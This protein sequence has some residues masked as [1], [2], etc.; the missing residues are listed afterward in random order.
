MPATVD[1]VMRLASRLY[2]PEKHGSFTYFLEAVMDLFCRAVRFEPPGEYDIPNLPYSH[3]R[4]AGLL[5]SPITDPENKYTSR[6][7]EARNF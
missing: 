5:A 1:D 4:M 3:F 6:C 7:I 2:N